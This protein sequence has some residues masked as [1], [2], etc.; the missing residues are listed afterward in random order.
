MG[1]NSRTLR[2]PT[3]ATGGV[4]TEAKRATVREPIDAFRARL[5]GSIDSA[6]ESASGAMLT[7]AQY[8]DVRRLREDV[9]THCAGNNRD[10]AEAAER[11]ALAI[12][13]EGPPAL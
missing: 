12:I 1:V 5:L 13:K 6:L 3:T 4:L 7:E 10:A 9:E 2:E 8:D 11:M